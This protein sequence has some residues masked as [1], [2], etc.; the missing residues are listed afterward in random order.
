MREG[1]AWGCLDRWER[2]DGCEQFIAMSTMLAH[3]DHS[4][5]RKASASGIVRGSNRRLKINLAH[6]GRALAVALTL[7]WC[8]MAHAQVA[9]GPL[10]S[11]HQQ[12]EGLTKCGSCHEFGTTSRGF[13]CLECHT[14]IRRRVDAKAG[15]HGREYKS[16]VGETDCRRC[17]QEHKGQT[18]PL[19]RLDRQNF[20]HLARTGFELV[21]KHR[22]Q[23]CGNC[24][25]ATSIVAGVRAEI[26]LKDVSRSFLVFAVNA[27][28]CQIHTSRA[29]RR[30]LSQVPHTEWL[31]AGFRIQS[32]R[33]AFPSHGTASEAALPRSATDRSLVKRL[34]SSRVWSSPAAKT[35]TTI[36]TTALFKRPISEDPDTTAT[37]PAAGRTTTRARSLI[38][39]ARSSGS[40]ESTPHWRARNVIRAPISIG[41]SL[42]SV[43]ATVMKTRTTGS[44]PNA[45][46][47]LIAASQRY[48]LQT[49]R[50]STVRRT[51]KARSPSKE[52][53]FRS[54]A[55]SAISR[56]ARARCTFRAS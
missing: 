42:T 17:H 56:R 39:R 29:A 4:H 54:I 46:P 11:V 32:W 7:W 16:S 30:R 33:H 52:S 8:A 9:P 22:E 43:V 25:V 51:V 47:D 6:P 3:L 19:I 48:G 10:S 14:E 21:G 35:V 36:L 13:K 49:P 20:D 38:T 2:R 44:S 24:H 15:F 41:R 1:E 18:T 50:A 28:A 45:R 37:I 40:P 55:R 34:R 23:K 12:L 31:Q 26:K 5:N 27:S 53:T